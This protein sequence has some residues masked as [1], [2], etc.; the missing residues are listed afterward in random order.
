MEIRNETGGD[1]EYMLTFD[2]PCA[3][4]MDAADE[5]LQE[6]MDASAQAGDREPAVPAGDCACCRL[7]VPAGDPGEFY[8]APWCGVCGHPGAAHAGATTFDRFAADIVRGFLVPACGLFAS[9]AAEPHDWW[10]P[11]NRAAGAIAG[12]VSTLDPEGVDRLLLAQGLTDA[13]LRG[14]AAAPVPDAGRKMRAMI[15]G[16]AGLLRRVAACLLALGV[17]R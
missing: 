6:R 3:G 1:V 9:P 15:A 17:D 5:Q 7:G 12:W 4:P 13:C 10:R 8:R 14:L 11:V 2:D 16:E